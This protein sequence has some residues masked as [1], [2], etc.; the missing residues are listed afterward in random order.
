M[1]FDA[2]FFDVQD[3]TRHAERRIFGITLRFRSR[4]DGSLCIGITPVDPLKFKLIFERFLNPERISMPDIDL[5]IQDDQRYKMLQYC[6]DKYGADR[7]HRLLRSNTGCEGA[8]R[9]VGG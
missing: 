7:V 1:G 8:I 3:L 5:D 9:D 4:F 6:S 2:L